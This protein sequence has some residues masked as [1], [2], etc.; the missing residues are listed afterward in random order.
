MIV[1]QPKKPTPLSVASLAEIKDWIRRSCLEKDPVPIL[2]RSD[3]R[4]E[5]EAR[6]REAESAIERARGAV[7]I[8][9]FSRR[10]LLGRM[11][12]PD[13]L[14]STL[15]TGMGTK[16]LDRTIDIE[17]LDIEDPA[18]DHRP[19][20]ERW[21]YNWLERWIRQNMLLSSQDP[22]EQVKIRNAIETYIHFRRGRP[23]GSKA[24]RKIPLSAVQRVVQQKRE[25]GRV[26]SY[27][28]VA[29]EL[30]QARTTVW[31]VCRD[32]GKKLEDL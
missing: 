17:D 14:R 22:L 25:D 18:K 24:G 10:A 2:E 20:G 7:I 9:D 26:V 28:T 19:N 1:R 5:L 31:R 11:C 13:F 8:A 29:R 4:R 32:A 21:A 16:G 27:T 3:S 6:V 15:S 12:S 23:K 30:G